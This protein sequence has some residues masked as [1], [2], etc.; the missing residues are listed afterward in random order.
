MKFCDD[1]YISKECAKRWR[2]F[3]DPDLDHSRWE[4]EEDTRLWAAVLS[5][6]SNWRKVVEEEF[7]GRSPTNVKNRWVVRS[8]NRCSMAENSEF[9]YAV[10]KNL[11]RRGKNSA[12]SAAGDDPAEIVEATTS[13]STK[14]ANDGCQ[15][16]SRSAADPDTPLSFGNAVYSAGGTDDEFGF[17]LRDSST[18]QTPYSL[19][20]MESLT[21]DNDS[22]SRFFSDSPHTTL[23]PSSTMRAQHC[24]NATTSSTYEHMP[25]VMDYGSFG[26]DDFP[27]MELGVTKSFGDEEHNE[28][29][30]ELQNGSVGDGCMP[31]PMEDLVADTSSSPSVHALGEARKVSLFLEDMQP[32]TANRVTTML[33]NGNVDLKMKMT[34]R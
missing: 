28:L 15:G 9:S 5:Y 25:D 30:W 21:N 19:T 23:A 2:H 33:L 16:F 31:S 17:L 1:S 6:G 32:E 29:C 24:S 22:T 20:G 3:L 4:P 8:I 14:A 13:L 26:L 7:P 12:A 10:I 11:R 34:I 27:Q 18:P